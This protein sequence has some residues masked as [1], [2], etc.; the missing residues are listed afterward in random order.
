MSQHTLTLNVNGED[1]EATVP[2]RRLLSDFLRDDLGLTGTKRGC[3][4]GICGACS[5][6]IDGQ[7]VKSCLSLAV[8]ARGKAIT[9]IEGIAQ[10]EQLHPVQASFMQCGGLQCGYCTPGMVMATCSMLKD[11]PRPTVDDIR[12][13][14]G[15]NLC[16]CTGYAQ[17]VESV[18]HAA[19]QMAETSHGN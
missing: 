10:G 7:V 16:R 1:I 13:G 18:L 9:T 2:A 14:L 12:H 8:Q 11:N 6:L 17:I 3:E 15:G 19:N 4:T 5:V